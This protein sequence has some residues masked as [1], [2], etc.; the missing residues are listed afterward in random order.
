M[1][2]VMAIKI[3]CGCGSV[4]SLHEELANGRVR[5]PVTCTNCGA[6]TT[7]RVN[8]AI[9]HRQHA[10]TTWWYRA[11]RGFAGRERTHAGRTPPA[12][13]PRTDA[14]SVGV[15][16]V[17]PADATPTRVMLGVVACVV[18]GA[19]G[20][21]AW[22]FLAR[23]TGYVFGATAWGI[24]ALIGAC[25]RYGLPD[26]S[27]RLAGLVAATAALAIVGGSVLTLRHVALRS[28]ERALPTAYV[29]A[30]ARARSALNLVDDDEIG[31]FLAQQRVGPEVSGRAAATP[32]EAIQERQ[33]VWMGWRPRG[34]SRAEPDRPP[35]FADSV[36]APDL[37]SVRA[38]EVAAFR[39]SGQAALR[40]FLEGQP[41]QREF[42]S[43]LR[44]KI[45]SRVSPRDLVLAG[46]GPYTA[47]WLLLGVG[48]AFKLARNKGPSV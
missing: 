4:L 2:A 8:A 26:A 12:S 3:K 47:L 20:M 46:A 5:W 40:G 16:T 17:T 29:D 33:L 41:S 21:L 32:I 37:E 45:L 44:Q 38:A 42:E 14:E 10:E 13:L 22:Y 48:T 39:E 36:R 28:I 9:A 31:E 18:A 6:D 24:G 30:R 15:V 35:G 27:R 1:N 43:Q 34:S 23:W 19:A 7:D 11:V 25:A